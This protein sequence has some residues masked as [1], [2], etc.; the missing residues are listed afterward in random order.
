VMGVNFEPHPRAVI[1]RRTSDVL[2]ASLRTDRLKSA[3]EG[4]RSFLGL[5]YRP[6]DPLSEETVP[7]R[8]RLIQLWASIV[9]S[10][11][12]TSR[13]RYEDPQITQ[14]VSSM[15][16]RQSD[17]ASTTHSSYPPALLR[18]EGGQLNRALSP[19]NSPPIEKID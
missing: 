4:R 12:A 2:F 15:H 1:G 8:V 7:R 5:Q 17:S 13:S 6:L 11:T 19:G 18:G 3:R 10:R 9:A 14:S 16:P